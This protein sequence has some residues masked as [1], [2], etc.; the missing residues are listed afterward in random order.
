MT[1]RAILT[2]PDAALRAVSAPVDAFD[3]TVA[4][5]IADLAQT[6]CARRAIGLS[7]PQILSLIHI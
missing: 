2:A 7:A 6:M 1:V 3:E 4:A 5:A